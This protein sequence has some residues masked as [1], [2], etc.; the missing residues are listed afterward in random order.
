MLVSYLQSFYNISHQLAK[1][2]I[3]LHFRVIFRISIYLNLVRQRISMIR[4]RSI[5]WVPNLA[6]SIFP[7]ATFSRYTASYIRLS[8]I[9]HSGQ[10]N[11]VN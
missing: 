4:I 8:S 11:L 1:C 10:D 9:S 2:Q 7:Y 3:R 5:R 6:Y